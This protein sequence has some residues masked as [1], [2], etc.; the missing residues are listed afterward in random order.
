MNK[1]YTKQIWKDLQERPFNFY[2]LE[3]VVPG[4]L[5]YLDFRIEPTNELRI[6][7][8]SLNDTH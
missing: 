4:S 7:S 2:S 3:T 5:W 6:L 8:L 1:T